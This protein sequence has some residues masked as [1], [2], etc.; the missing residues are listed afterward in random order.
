[1]EATWR[2]Q[3]VLLGHQPHNKDELGEDLKEHRQHIVS[4]EEDSF[5]CRGLFKQKKKPKGMLIW[6]KNGS[7]IVHCHNYKCGLAVCKSGA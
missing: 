4:T 1:M 5:T 3:F 6:H 7:G 2:V